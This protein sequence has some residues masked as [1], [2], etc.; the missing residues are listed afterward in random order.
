VLCESTEPRRG[1]RRAA[2]RSWLPTS[3]LRTT[4]VMDR[5]TWLLLTPNRERPLRHI[6]TIAIDGEQ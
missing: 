1:R 2:L 3:C 5:S 4:G 6:G